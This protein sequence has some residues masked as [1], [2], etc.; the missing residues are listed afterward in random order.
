MIKDSQL[1]QEQVIACYDKLAKAGDFPDNT[2]LHKTFE[3]IIDAHLPRRKTMRV[4]DAG[5]G[6]GF[7]GIKLAE[8]E[9]KVFILDISAASLVLA[10]RRSLE[11]GCSVKV[12]TVVGNIQHIPFTDE[13]FDLILC[14]FVFSHLNDPDTAFGELSRCLHPGGRLFISFE[15]RLWHVVAAG[16]SERYDE[17]ISLMSTKSPF[18]EAYDIL[19]SV[20]L[21]SVSEIKCLCKKHRMEIELFTGVRYVSSFQ[22]TLRGIGTTDAEKLMH[23]KPLALKLENM[24]IDSGELLPLAR[25]FLLRCKRK[26]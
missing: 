4:L 25:H 24:L 1:S 23:D 20:R 7:F 8:A 18:I 3:Q 11:R 6:A 22:E 13:V 2:Y 17:A 14:I 26:S 15:N 10:R 21:Y 9:H 12:T 5:G 19:P 16:L